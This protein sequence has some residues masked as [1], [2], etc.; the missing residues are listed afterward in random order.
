MPA[1]ALAKQEEIN[2]GRK[3]A[4]RYRDSSKLLMETLV[5]VAVVGDMIFFMAGLLAAFDLRFDLPPLKYLRLEHE[6]VTLWN[7]S[8]HFIFGSVLFSILAARS[9][10]YLRQNI[11]RSRRVSI[12]LLNTSAYWTLGYLFISL[13]FYF[14]PPI[15]RVFVL[16]GAIC[17]TLFVFIWRHFFHIILL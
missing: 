6:V 9:G 15:S 1:H 13:L 12:A 4:H 16:L 10:L 11:L 3:A 8:S 17:G 14:H 7:Y 5:A 2:L